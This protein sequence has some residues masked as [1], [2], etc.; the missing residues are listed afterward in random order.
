MELYYPNILYVHH[1]SLYIPLK[2]NFFQLNYIIHH[3]NFSIAYY[4]LSL[5][6]ILVPFL[7]QIYNRIKMML[8]LDHLN[9]IKFHQDRIKQRRMKDYYY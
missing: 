6:M 9:L 7:L 8:L 1:E 2:S 4:L 5:E 3:I